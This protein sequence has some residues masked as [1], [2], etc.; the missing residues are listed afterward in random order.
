MDERADLPVSGQGR[1]PERKESRGQPG[2]WEAPGD[3]EGGP[4][5]CFRLALGGSGLRKVNAGGLLGD[6][7]SP[8]IGSFI[9]SFTHAANSPPVCR[10]CAG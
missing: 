8:W 2:L 10:S 4:L 7:R 1:E 6:L 3:Q 5:L 9:H